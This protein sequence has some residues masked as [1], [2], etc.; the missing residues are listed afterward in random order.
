M[1]APTVDQ[2][3]Q[4]LDDAAVLVAA[5]DEEQWAAPTP[6]TDWTVRQL[7]SHLVGGNLLFAAIV[8]GL[9][10]DRSSRDHLGD[11]PMAAYR[12]AARAVVAAFGRPG[13]L[14]QLVTVPFGTVPGVVALHLR[15][16]EVLV[17]GWDLARAI[18]GQTAFPAD[19]VAQELEFTRAA[20]AELPPDRRPFGPPRPVADDA[21]L[22]DQLAACLGRSASS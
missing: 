18:S 3:A 13:A 11:D 2:L 20:L 4:V 1:A 5:V 7:V 17:H 8:D 16:T 15:I 21:P 6:C 10:V 12:A 9:P 22:I 19:L 14:E